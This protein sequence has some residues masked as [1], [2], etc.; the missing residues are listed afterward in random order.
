MSAVFTSAGRIAA[1]GTP[2]PATSH[3]QITRRLFFEQAGWASVILQTQGHSRESI[4]SPV[5][6]LH[7]LEIITGSVLKHS[8][9]IMNIIKHLNYLDVKWSSWFRSVLT[10]NRQ[11]RARNMNKWSCVISAALRGRK[12]REVYDTQPY[13]NRCTAPVCIY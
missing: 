12:R 10:F 13:L 7:G 11:I 8:F 5:V 3:Q 4:V 1:S 6:L 9:A 2:F